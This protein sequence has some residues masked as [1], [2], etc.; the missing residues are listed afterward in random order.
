VPGAAG[1]A[2]GIDLGLYVRQPAHRIA[3]ERVEKRQAAGTRRHMILA[4]LPRTR[5]TSSGPGCHG[6][7]KRCAGAWTPEP[8]IGLVRHQQR[9]KSYPEDGPENHQHAVSFNDP[10]S[11]KAR[12]CALLKAFAKFETNS[13]GIASSPV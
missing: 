9:H 13:P 1:L 12:L 6:G 7:R 8:K 5:E 10:D 11:M 2:I 4:N 3:L